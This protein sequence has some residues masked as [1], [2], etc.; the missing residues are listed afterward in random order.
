[1]N[2]PNN[3][4]EGELWVLYHKKIKEYNQLVDDIRQILMDIAD[5]QKD[6]QEPDFEG[7]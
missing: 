7:W 5:R 6:K 2:Y 1:M 4:T 3:I